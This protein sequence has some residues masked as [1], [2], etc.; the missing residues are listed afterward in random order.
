[1]NSRSK[2]QPNKFTITVDKRLNG[3]DVVKMSAE[4]LKEANETLRK[5]RMPDS[6][7]EQIGKY[8]T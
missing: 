5:V 8:R 7:Y 2:R 3:L 1:M 6:Y 4:K